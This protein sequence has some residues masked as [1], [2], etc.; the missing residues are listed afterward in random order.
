MVP[1]IIAECQ[2]ALFFV[3]AELDD[4]DMMCVRPRRGLMKERAT[5]VVLMR[6]VGIPKPLKRG[7]IRVYRPQIRN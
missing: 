4:V 5:C 1:K 7:T 6:H 2:R 3:A